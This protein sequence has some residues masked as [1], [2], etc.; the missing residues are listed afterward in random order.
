MFK[1]LSCADIL[2]HL[3][4]SRDTRHGAVLDLCDKVNRSQGRDAVAKEAARSIRKVLK[5]SPDTDRRMAVRVWW[6][7]MRNIEA[8]NYPRTCSFPAEVA[9]D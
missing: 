4:S 2:G 8:S 6:I 7:T 5:S 9:H 3:C 1:N